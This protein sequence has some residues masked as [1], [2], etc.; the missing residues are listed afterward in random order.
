MNQ[1]GLDPLLIITS[2]SQSVNC[3]QKKIAVIII[4][5][6]NDT[7]QNSVI[8]NNAIGMIMIP[9]M[10]FL[11]PD[12]GLPEQFTPPF[13]QWKSMVTPA[14]VLLQLNCICE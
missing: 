6:A 5:A 3:K 4:S 2:V 8:Y 13:S 14:I 9:D 12:L 11:N 1:E 7:S 10:P